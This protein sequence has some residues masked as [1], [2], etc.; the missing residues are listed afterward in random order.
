MRVT[1]TTIALAVTTTLTGVAI[2][3]ATDF[4]FRPEFDSISDL[5][6]DGRYI[7]G[8]S[9]A[10]GAYRYDL[11]ANA[12]LDLP[13]PG[14][15]AAAVSDDGRTVLGSIEVLIAGETKT[16]AAIWTED[17]GVWTSLGAL[18]EADCGYSRSS[19]YEL[20]ADGTVAIG[21]SWV[22]CN[23][24]GFRWTA[25]TG[26]L[27]LENLANGTNRASVVSAD[28]N[29]IAGFAQGSF[30]RTPAIWGPSGVGA[31]LDPPN[32]DVIGEIHGISDDGTILL[33]TWDG[34]AT[35]FTNGGTVRQT[36]GA[37]SLLPGWV[38]NPTDIANDG[39]IVG[40][41]TLGTNR[42][43]WIV[44]AGSEVMIDLRTY[45]IGLGADVPDGLNLEVAS[46]ISVDGGVIVG[47]G[48]T[49]AWT[50]V[51]DQPIACLGDI[52]PP[53]GNGLVDIDDLSAILVAWGTPNADVN[54]DGN[55]DA[56]DL[57]L[58]LSGWGAC[59]APTGACC[60]AD[61]CE[62]LSAEE[63]AALGGT[64]RGAGTPCAIASC[65][66]NDRCVDAID[67]TDHING[68]I[69]EGDNTTATPGFDSFIVDIDRP[70][71]SPSCQWFGEPNFAHSSVWYAFDAPASGGVTVELC[72][73]APIPFFDSTL[74][75]YSG[76]CG[77]LVEIACDED[78]CAPVGEAPF[79]SRAVA[80]GLT[81]GETYHVC[82]MNAGGWL[83]SVP[84]PFRM[85]IRST[86]G[87]GK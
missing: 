1:S 83:G 55:T 43:A 47:H 78:G 52:A 26:M 5:S 30:S 87:F 31:L 45:L 62:A 68:A 77:G 41:D 61:G 32:G 64:F 44:P 54:G 27:P 35:K 9:D 46:A 8:F 13:L 60:L 34:K 72:S 25:D 65:V 42:R 29:L 50:A 85:S 63:C 79:Y 21:L 19:P 51:L 33:G 82:V 17:S 70:S 69:V 3:G 36:I 84:G 37:G 7:V 23:S 28:G 76:V 66:S 86:S 4:Q 81:P 56:A 14:T 73:S 10:G 40:Y 67:I 18:P 53:G 49:G 12:R 75:I 71:G 74:A 57:A 39:T 6:P 80:T 48:F 24:H 59:P 58:V 15:I 2:A 20:S 16:E 38:S 22:G 11:F